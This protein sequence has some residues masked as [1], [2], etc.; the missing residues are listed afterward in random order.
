MG[1]DTRDPAAALHVRSDAPWQRSLRWETPTIDSRT[2][3]PPLALAIVL[4]VLQWL[5]LGLAM[6]RQIRIATR[7][8][9]SAPIRVYLIDRAPS[10][11]EPP[12][13]E[14]PPRVRESTFRV[15][16]PARVVSKSNARATPAPRTVEESPA[17]LLLFDREGRIRLPEAS[18]AAPAA[19]SDAFARRNPLPYTAMRFENAFAPANESLGEELVRRSTVSHTW[20]TPWGTEISCSVTLILGALGGCGWG[21]PR[22]ATPEEL[23]AMRADPPMPKK[24]HDHLLD[25]RAE[26]ADSA[27]TPGAPHDQGEVEH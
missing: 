10:V 18:P 19:K 6:H 11:A 7:V 17:S 1:T 3:L 2:L 12:M 21:E 13:P 14:P 25:R 4:T 5:A 22:R 24:L 27:A 26:S 9:S 23:H 16:T 8:G 20:R 15:E